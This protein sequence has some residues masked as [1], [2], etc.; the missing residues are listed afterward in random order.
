MS[1][2]SVSVAHE[3]ILGPLAEHGPASPNGHRQRAPQVIT[4][5]ASD[6][7][8]SPR[9]LGRTSPPD[10]AENNWDAKTPTPAQAA[11]RPSVPARLLGSTDSRSSGMNGSAGRSDHGVGEAAARA[12]L[13][14]TKLHVPAIGA[15]LVHR[16]ALLET[17]SAG[18]SRKLTANECAG[19]LGQDDS[20]GA[21]GL[22]CGRGPAVRL[23]VARFLRQRPGVVLDVRRRRAAEGQ[24]RGGDSRGRTPRDGRRPDCRS[25]CLPC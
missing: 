18:R 21:V 20:T 6:S 4:E 7:I 17:L 25:F 9:L 8:G 12:V 22:G 19:G 16:A 1:G 24:S 5:N 15:Q 3:K 14:A 2:H 10:P 11:P 13:L 23:A